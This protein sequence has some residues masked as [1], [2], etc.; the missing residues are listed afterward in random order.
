[1]SKEITKEEIDRKAN[2][3]WFPVACRLCGS[4]TWFDKDFYKASDFARGYECHR[5]GKTRL[6]ANT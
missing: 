6:E 3:G 4:I 2:E 1:M 5:H